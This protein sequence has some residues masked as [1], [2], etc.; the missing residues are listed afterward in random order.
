MDVF[1]HCVA[2]KTG[3]RPRPGP[4]LANV[5]LPNLGGLYIYL[6]L[7]Q[8]ILSVCMYI[9]I[10]N[11]IQCVSLSLSVSLSL[12]IYMYIYIYIIFF[13]PTYN[14]HLGAT[15]RWLQLG[16]ESRWSRRAAREDTS[17]SLRK[18]RRHV[19]RKASR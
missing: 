5:P 19:R 10:C 15:S 16:D 13:I 14:F 1:Q 8:I 7:D 6:F 4:K 3:K 18:V 11:F 12:H 2:L 17:K 9:C